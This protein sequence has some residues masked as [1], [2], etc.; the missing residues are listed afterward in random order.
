MG[1]KIACGWPTGLVVQS[2]DVRRCSMAIWQTIQ[3]MRELG[4]SINA[5]WPALC[6]AFS[7]DCNLIYIA[8]QIYG[9]AD[10]TAC[11]WTY[12]YE[13]R[14]YVLKERRQRG[15]D[16]NHG[17]LTV[18]VE[19]W[20]E[21]NDEPQWIHAREPLIYVGFDPMRDSYWTKTDMKLD[22]H[23]RFRGELVSGR[24]LS[25]EQNQP[26]WKYV[27][28]E[29]REENEW[30]ERSWFFVLPLF[31]IR[32]PIDIRTEIVTPIRRLFNGD[33]PAEAFVGTNAIP[34]I[35]DE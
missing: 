21:V 6:T 12:I 23:G 32:S 17:H 2:I 24:I 20:R 19:L 34:T 15:R 10:C 4:S 1:T 25:C 5:F 13:N 31:S 9:E 26:L 18:G 11:Q 30:K 16:K 3:N 27:Y 29:I 14:V 35:P 33:G 22:Q 7:R 8:E 28:E